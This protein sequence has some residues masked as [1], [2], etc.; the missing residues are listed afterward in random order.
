MAEKNLVVRDKN[1]N[2]FIRIC[3]KSTQAHKHVK[4]KTLKRD[5]L[6]LLFILHFSRTKG[7]VFIG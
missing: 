5:E 6:M 1:L 7:K 3:K 2:L 4:K